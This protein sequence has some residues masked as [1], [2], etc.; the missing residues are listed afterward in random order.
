LAVTVTDL[1]AVTVGAVKITVIPFVLSREP[2]ETV[3][4]M[5][6]V[7]SVFPA[8]S[9]AVKTVLLPETAE[10]PDGVIPRA[11]PLGNQEGEVM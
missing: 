1:L 7:I 8:D 3:Q 10:P 6:P 9:M 5:L 4:E 2:S 11:V